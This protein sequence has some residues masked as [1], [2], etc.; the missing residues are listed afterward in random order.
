MKLSL[1]KKLSIAFLITVL[2][3]LILTS[4]ISNYYVNKN[5]QQYLVHEHKTKIDN[6]IKLVEDIYNEQD[7]FSNINKDEIQRYSETQELYIEIKDINNNVIYTSGSS[8]LQHRNMM[9]NMME[10]STTN[11][12]MMTLEDYTESDYVLTK[13]DKN[14]GAMTIGYFGT[15]YL[16]AGSVTFINTLNKSF[17]L[18]TIIALFFGFIVSIVISK[19]I[20]KPITNIT[21]IAN[22]MRDGDLKVRSLVNTN[23]EELYELSNS[24]NYL[25][26]TLNNQEM[27]RKRLTSDISHELRTPLTTLKTHLEAFI[28]GIW[29][30]TTER[31][32]TFHEEIDRLTKLVDNLRNLAKLEEANFNLNKVNI[33]ISKELEKIIDT[34]KPLYIKENYQLTSSITPDINLK[35]DKDKFR[36]IMNNL[37]SNSYRYLIPNG[38][39][40]IILKKEKHTVLIEVIDNGIGIPEEDIPYIFERFYRSDISR[41]KNTGG[42]GIGLT[43]TKRLVESHDGKIS[44]KSKLNEGTKFIIELPLK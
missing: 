38:K 27:L 39:V 37:L 14:I 3:S 25:A 20:S 35:V 6:I 28:D 33:N 24:I 9:Q 32:E 30:P 2:I 42:S 36:Q 41:A 7:Q 29:E 10:S 15:S 31:L 8:H 19:Q 1:V 21:H 11:F 18:S 40:Q 13:N 44:V 26:E 5:F 4:F 22:K 23:T 16:S 12:Y 17:I 34:F 43:I